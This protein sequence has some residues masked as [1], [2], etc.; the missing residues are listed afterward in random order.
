MDEGEKPFPIEFIVI[1]L[2]VAVAN[3]IAEIFFDILDFTGVGIAGEAIME[4]VNFVLDFFFTGIFW[5]KVGP[6]GGTITQYIGDLLEPFFIPGRTISVGL[7]MWI[8]NNPNSVIGKVA[9]TAASLETGNVAG[10][11]GEAEGVA[12]KIEEVTNAEKKLQS[13]G[14]ASGGKTGTESEANTSEQQA[15]TGEPG[16][17]TGEGDGG[18]GENAPGDNT[19][20]NPLDNPVGTAGQELNEPPEEKFHEG[21]GFKPSEKPQK[22]VDIESRRSAPPKAKPQTENIDEEFS[23]EKAA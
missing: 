20:T 18:K 11:A 15:P 13:E 19:F 10:A 2:I 14:A 22:V 7:G 9:T 23:E 5:W 12:G 16:S 17:P 21:E 3:D 4:P 6:G 8:A 1:L